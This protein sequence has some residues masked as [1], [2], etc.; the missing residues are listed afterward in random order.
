ACRACAEGCV[1]GAGRLSARRG[2]RA[3]AAGRASEGKIAAPFRL[4]RWTCPM[5]PAFRSFTSTAP[6]GSCAGNLIVLRER[7]LAINDLEPPKTL[8]PFLPS[9]LHLRAE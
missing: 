8:A 7:T 3:L 6:F 5:R 1:D 9:Y 2:F 4:P